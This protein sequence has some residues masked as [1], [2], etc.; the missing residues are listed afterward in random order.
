MSTAV[1]HPV[2]SLPALDAPIVRNAEHHV[3]PLAD[4][5]PTTR[6]HVNR[7]ADGWEWAVLTRMVIG[8][9]VVAA[10][11]LPLADHDSHESAGAWLAEQVRGPE[12]DGFDRIPHD[13]Y[14][15]TGRDAHVRTGADTFMGYCGKTGTPAVWDRQDPR[16]VE[17]HCMGCDRAYRAAHYGRVA[18]EAR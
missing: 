12:G 7:T 8:W 11:V 3:K 9:E 2:K 13:A 14:S 17:Q 10:G 1:V 16:H 15:Q 4:Q 5:T 6:V 18:V